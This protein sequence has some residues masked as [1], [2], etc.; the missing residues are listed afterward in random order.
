MKLSGV[1][2]HHIQELLQLVMKMILPLRCRAWSTTRIAPN[3]GPQTG[4]SSPASA[5]VYFSNVVHMYLFMFVTLIIVMKYWQ[6]QTASASAK[7]SN[8]YIIKNIWFNICQYQFPK[9]L[10]QD[11]VT[12]IW[13]YVKEKDSGGELS[14]CLGD[15]GENWISILLI[16]CTNSQ[17]YARLSDTLRPHPLKKKHECLWRNF[18][19]VIGTFAFSLWW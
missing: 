13:H 6:I 4:C 9:R 11:Y 7:Y 10:V 15:T 2:C 19:D 3:P 1:S 16:Y 14:L 12:R 17:I 8:P 18:S 5:S